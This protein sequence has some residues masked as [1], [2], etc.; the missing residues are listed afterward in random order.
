[1]YSPTELS[2]SQA[3][4]DFI[5]GEEWVVLHLYNDS[6]D[7]SEA[8]CTV[9]IGHL[10][11]PG[12]CDGSDSE[13]EFQ[14]GITEE[15]AYE[16]FASDL[17]NR[18]ERYVDILVTVPLTQYQYDALV[19][20]VFNAGSGR[21]ENSSTLKYLNQSNYEA[22]GNAMESEFTGGRGPVIERRRKESEMF[23]YGTYD[24]KEP[25]VIP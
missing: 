13:S 21:F 22:A 3:G 12:Q 4:F 7:L 23:R 14:D 16:L 2:L 11:H 5:V 9:G 10:V 20:F 6:D 18:A 25:V 8:N 1:M 19:S 24:I 15:R 17:D